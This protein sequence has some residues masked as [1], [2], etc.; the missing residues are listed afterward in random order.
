VD[1]FGGLRDPKRLVRG[2][3]EALIADERRRA[4]VHIGWVRRVEPEAST[5]R[6]AQRIVEGWTRVAAIEGGLTG[7]AGLLGVPLNAVLFAYCQLAVAV[8]VAEAYGRTLD[9][10]AGEDAVLSVI[11]RAHGVEELV[12]AGPRVL[13]AL[14]KSLAVRRGLPLLGR[15]VPFVAAPVGARLNRRGLE[16]TAEEALRRFGRVVLVPPPACAPSAR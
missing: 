13:G 10:A 9:G 1:V 12:R 4:R 8:G 15:A 7:A 2:R 6:V 11:G 3:L 16:R 14:A 5:D